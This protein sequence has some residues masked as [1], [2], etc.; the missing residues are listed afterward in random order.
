MHSP[1]VLIFLSLFLFSIGA[2]GVIVRRNLIIVFM[3]I[4]LM[5]NSANLLLVAFSHF[6]KN[7]DGMMFVLFVLAIAAAEAG[8]A[9]ALFVVLFRQ[10]GKIDSL[11]INIL[12]H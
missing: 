8:V 9:L 1:A 10:K 4:E 5:L 3:C 6:L 7:I 12:K 2:V 11:Q